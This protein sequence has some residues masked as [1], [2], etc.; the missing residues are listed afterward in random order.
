ML[1]SRPEL[2]VHVADV[3]CPVFACIVPIDEVLFGHIHYQKGN[4]RP[5]MCP[6]FALVLSW[7]GRDKGRLADESRSPIPAQGWIT[8]K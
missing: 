4:R 6:C 7:V 5:E 3:H 1:S 2:L 8:T